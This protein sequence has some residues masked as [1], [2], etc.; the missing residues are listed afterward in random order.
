MSG[1]GQS[2]QHNLKHIVIGIYFILFSGFIFILFFFM[3]VIELKELQQKALENQLLLSHKENEN[4]V[5]EKLREKESILSE[6]AN[7]METELQCVICSE[8]F[9]QVR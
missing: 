6:F 2:T 5:K 7:T 4:A 9:V 1:E 8:L 3:Q